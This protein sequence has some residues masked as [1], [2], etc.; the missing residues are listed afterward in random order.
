ML[1]DVGVA[2]GDRDLLDADLREA[3][4]RGPALLGERRGDEVALAALHVVVVEGE[5]VLLLLAKTRYEQDDG[6]MEMSME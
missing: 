5:E 4:A 3:E 6:G 2:A 1:Q